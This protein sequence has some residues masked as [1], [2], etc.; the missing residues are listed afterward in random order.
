MN[1][2]IMQIIVALV[3]AILLVAL[4]PLVSGIGRKF[5][6]KMHTRRG[7]SVFQDYYD[8]AKLLKREDVHSNHASAISRITPPLYIAAMI[9]LAMGIPMYTAASPIPV[10]GDMILIIYMLAL[11]RFFFSLSGLDSGS[12][13]AGTGGVRELILGTLVEPALMLALFV[14]AL[15]CGTTNVGE[16]GL[17]VSSGAVADPVAY[18]VAG[19]AFACACYVEMGKLP[20][21]LA[22]AEQELQEGPLSE[23]SGPSLAM[24]HIAVPMKQTL[25]AALFLAIFIPFGS[26]VDYS[27][28]G[29]LTGTV[30][31][32]IKMAVI[33]FITM[34]LENVVSRVRWKI[35]GHQTWFIVGI[36]AVSFV[37]CLMGI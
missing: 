4:A 37:F 36:A 3:Q 26:S 6:A 34:V 17:A 21:D 11:P 28:M 30:V 15:A 33:L 9:V 27:F 24:M 22:E 1:I 19:V 8:I 25:M 16:M 14:A 31:F 7:P 10:L 2:D 20:Y 18:V 13:Y 5:R 12:A 32:V 29:L 35:T 23:M